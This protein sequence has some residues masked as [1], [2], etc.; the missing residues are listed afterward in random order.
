MSVIETERLLLR[1][2]TEEDA[3][4]IYELL[5]SPGW[6]KYIGTRG[7]ADLEAARK[8]IADIMV[9]SYEKNGFGFY[10]MVRKNDGAEM[11]MCGL[12]KRDSLEDVDIGFAILPEYE[13]K[14]CTGEAAAATLV[15]ARDTLGLKRIA[16]ITVSYNKGSIQLMEKLEM[17][18]ER[19]IRLPNDE[20]EL[21]LYVKEF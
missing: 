8:Y 2:F 5:N 12:I 4:F 20:E 7:I 3:P 16:G 17:K 6:L 9:P 1:E 18:F 19:M 13:G 10:M 11:G 21:M 15:Y 14:G